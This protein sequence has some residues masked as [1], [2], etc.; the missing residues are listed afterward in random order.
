MSNDFRIQLED[1]LF[2]VQ[3]FF[4]IIPDRRFVDTLKAFSKGIG[5][6]FNDVECAFPGE[7]EFGEEVINGIE[8]ALHHHE[9]VITYN[10]FF[11]ILKDVCDVFINTNKTKKDEVVTL[12]MEIEV[13]L[14]KYRN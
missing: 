10:Q 6:G 5:A 8:F 3:A 9:V 14:L 2:P 13:T 1:K 4:N 11:S 12:L 7:Q